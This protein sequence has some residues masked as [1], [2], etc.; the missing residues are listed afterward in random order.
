MKPGDLLTKVRRKGLYGTLRLLCACCLY[1]HWRLIWLQRDLSQAPPRLQRRHHWRYQPITR[2]L[3]PA[4]E[5]HFAQHRRVMG[6]LLEQEGVRGIAAIDD[7]G[8]VCAFLWYSD[9]DYYDPHYYRCWF[10]VTPPSVYLFALEVAPG[11]RGSA[12]LVVGQEQLWEQL[13]ALGFQRALAVVEARNLPAR[14]LLGR[15]GFEPMGWQTGIFT[16]LGCLRFS[17]QPPAVRRQ[18]SRPQAD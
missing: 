5:H 3:L 12:L 18:L 15:L 8:H 10:P 1:S 6:E 14:K 4:F 13:R 11:H 17:C 9:R 7:Q 16:L 2:E